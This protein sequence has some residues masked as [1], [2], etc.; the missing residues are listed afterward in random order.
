MVADRS[1]DLNHSSRNALALPEFM[2]RT[3]NL[4]PSSQR[5][6]RVPVATLQEHDV[7]RRLFLLLRTFPAPLVPR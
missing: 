6:Q 5:P 1:Y 2:D 3:L 7:A 4:P